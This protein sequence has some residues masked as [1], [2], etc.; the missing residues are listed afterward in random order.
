MA[1]DEAPAATAWPSRE[2]ES[3]VSTLTRTA[4]RRC[5]GNPFGIEPTG[6]SDSRLESSIQIMCQLGASKNMLQNQ[7]FMGIAPH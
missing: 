2:T 5:C 3:T 1:R 4:Q 6:I 7:I